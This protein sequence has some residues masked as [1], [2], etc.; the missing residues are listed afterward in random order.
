VALSGQTRQAG[1]RG[2]Q[3]VAPISISACAKLAGAAGGGQRSRIAAMASRLAPMG[4]EKPASRG[5][6]ARDI[7]VDRRRRLVEGDRGDG[8]RGIGADSGQREQPRLVGRE[9]AAGRSDRARAGVQVARPRDSSRGRRRRSSRSSIGAAASALTSGQRTQELEVVGRG[10]RRRRLLQQDFREPDAIGVPA[11]AGP[12]RHG[13]LRA[14]ASYQA[15]ALAASGEG[16]RL[17]GMVEPSSASSG[18]PQAYGHASG[19]MSAAVVGPALAAP[20]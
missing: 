9:R 12:A 16:A 8:G 13:S 5:D 14:L 20:A 11:D 3:I 15:S 6:D 19:A 2:R 10:A 1:A 18:A 7:A 4:A 17:G